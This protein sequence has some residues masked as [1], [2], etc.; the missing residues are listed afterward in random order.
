M[1]PI[2]AFVA[3]FPMIVKYVPPASSRM[4]GVPADLLEDALQVLTGGLVDLGVADRVDGH[5][6]A[7]RARLL[8]ELLGLGHVVRV[9]KV[10]FLYCGY[11]GGRKFCVVFPSPPRILTSWSR[12]IP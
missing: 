9:L 11:V 12:S 5:L 3:W 2:W 1:K 6:H 8:H 10:I 7:L 4:P